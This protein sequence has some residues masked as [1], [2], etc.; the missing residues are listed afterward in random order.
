MNQAK[1]NVLFASEW[2]A[3]VEVMWRGRLES[4]LYSD[5]SR[6]VVEGFSLYVTSNGS[7][8][9]F[10][11]LSHCMLIITP[12]WG[13]WVSSVLS[14]LEVICKLND[15]LSNDGSVLSTKYSLLVRRIP[16]K[17]TGITWL[18]LFAGQWVWR[19]KGSRR[20]PTSCQS[21]G[22]LGRG[23]QDCRMCSTWPRV[24]VWLCEVNGPR[25]AGDGQS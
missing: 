8:M 10:G 25:S 1:G 12:L 4:F 23:T 6:L 11:Q 5:P 15:L 20:K 19:N 13:H 9:V 22:A 14:F 3:C 7:G 17:V 21:S 16:S 18:W 2:T 24:G